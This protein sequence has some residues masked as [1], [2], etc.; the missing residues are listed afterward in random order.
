MP[1]IAVFPDGPLSWYVRKGEIKAGYYNPADL[2]DRV[3]I[4]SPALEEAPLDKIRT[5]GGDAT[6][7]LHPSGWMSRWSKRRFLDLRG[8]L[9]GELD[10]L[11]PVLADFRPDAIRG[12]SPQ[13]QSW[14]AVHAAERLGVPA[15]VSL[16]ADF[17]RDIRARLLHDRQWRPFVAQTILG[18]VVEPDVLRRADAVICV[19]RF[20]RRYAEKKGARRVEVIHNRVDTDRFRPAAH[21]PDRPFTV[22]IVSRLDPDRDP[23]NVVRA[24]AS[25]SGR[26][27]I[28]GDGPLAGAIRRLGDRL[29][30]GARLEMSPAV[31]HGEIDHEY[32]NADAYAA[33]NQHGG[34]TI[35]VLEA[36]ASGLPVVAART[37]SDPFPDLVSEVGIF[38]DNTAEGFARALRQLQ[39]DPGLRAR[40]GASGR[41]LMERM[42]A[43]AMAPREAHLYRELMASKT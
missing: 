35:P 21:R 13:I 17:D 19:Y 30:M 37:A 34:V 12:Y 7:T 11:M 9:E 29:G 28:V 43:N 16:H 15:V 31:P 26:L 18:R 22:L 42:G 39:E 1:R 38:V 3:L 8:F 14:L 23:S 20:I 2:F 40:L 41:A 27:R 6:V 32:R 36:M 33:S 5:M 24:M 25:L 10:R 4:V